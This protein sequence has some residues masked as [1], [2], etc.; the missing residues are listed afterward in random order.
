MIVN[1]KVLPT[2]INGTMGCAWASAAQC[3]KQHG[4]F[5]KLSIAIQGQSPLTSRYFQQ[6]QLLRIWPPE[7]WSWGWRSKVRRNPISDPLLLPASRSFSW[8]CFR[9]ILLTMLNFLQWKW[10]LRNL[11]NI[12][13]VSTSLFSQGHVIDENMAFSSK[14]GWGVQVKGVV[15]W[16]KDLLRARTTQVCGQVSPPWA[17]RWTGWI[18]WDWGLFLL[19]SKVNLVFCQFQLV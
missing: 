6:C 8:S 7:V 19:N 14:N 12:F 13:H 2:G 16:L 10:D 18:A 1:G 3:Y 11:K 4:L 5:T 15:N 9:L 17:L